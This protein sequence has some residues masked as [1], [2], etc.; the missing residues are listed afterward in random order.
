[1]SKTD[2]KKKRVEELTALLAPF[3][4]EYMDSQL[5]G[6]VLKLLSKLSR[7]R[8]MDICKGK[9]EVWAGSIIY[10]IA[11]LNF[12]FDKDQD[13][14]VTADEI[15]DFFKVKKSTVANKATR[16]EESCTNGYMDDSFSRR[17]LPLQ[18]C[19]E[20]E[21]GFII[22]LKFDGEME[23]EELVETP[24][25]VEAREFFEAAEGRGLLKPA[26]GIAYKA[27]K[28]A[29]AE[30]KRLEKER[31]REELQKL[32]AI[33]AEKRKQEQERKQPSLFDFD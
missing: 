18:L 29:K 13:Y 20:D 15:A 17:S 19:V 12:M 28:A 33:E 21:M 23:P 30:E 4:L 32:A 2:S 24:E 6:F 25:E 10:T 26:R 11:R 16:I 22:P 9:K 31:A 8:T 1:M 7:K 14:W 5:Y 3:A 27:A